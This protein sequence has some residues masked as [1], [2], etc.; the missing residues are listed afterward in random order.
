MFQETAD[1]ANFQ[2]RYVIRHE[3]N[4][5]ADCPEA[6]Q[7]RAGLAERRAKQAVTLAELTGWDLEKIRGKMALAADWSR[8]EDRMRWW[9]RIWKP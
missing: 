9:E 3:W 1:R 6:L 2:G 8:P 5:T 4:G 7:Y